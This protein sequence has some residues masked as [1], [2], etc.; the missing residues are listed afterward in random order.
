MR[1]FLDGAWKITKLLD[2]GQDVVVAL[3]ELKLKKTVDAIVVRSKIGSFSASR[4]ALVAGETLSAVWGVPTIFVEAEIETPEQ[5]VAAIEGADI[6]TDAAFEYE[7]SPHITMK[8][9]P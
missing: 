3:H 5:L 8:K 9:I 1:V 4:N 7:H 6:K 2:H